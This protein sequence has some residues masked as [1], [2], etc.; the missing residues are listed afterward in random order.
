MDSSP[1][2]TTL[3]SVRF[4]IFFLGSLSLSLSLIISLLSLFPVNHRR[5]FSTPKVTWRAICQK[6][7]KAA[8]EGRP[9]QRR[10]SA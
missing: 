6:A 3:T 10:D 1:P 7:L 8:K 9:P 2:S 4:L 5:F